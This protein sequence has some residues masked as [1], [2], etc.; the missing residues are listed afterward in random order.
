[1]RIKLEHDGQFLPPK[2]RDKAI[3]IVS[4]CLKAITTS[5]NDFVINDSLYYRKQ[6]TGKVTTC[7]MNS[8]TYISKN[9][10]DNLGSIDG[11]FG[12]TPL[13]GQN[14]DG[15]IAIDFTSDGYRIR[16]RDKLLEVLH[17]YIEEQGLP[18]NSIYTLFPMFYGMYVDKG[19]YDISCLPESTK[20]L[21]TPSSNTTKFRLGV[22]F[23]TG[24][25]ASSFRALNKLFVL[26]QQRYI[27]AGVFVTSTDK[28]NS[29]T[30]IWP[31]SN[32]NGSFQE[33]RQRR[34]M[35]QISLPVIC[36]GF[37]PDRFDSNA[38]FL[39]K[40]LNLYS[41]TATGRMDDSRTR[42]VFL[43]EDGEEILRPI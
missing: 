19:L 8:A 3:D 1:M 38:Q 26:F 4:N 29:S 40:R 39:G 17:L 36:I 22:E 25:V 34:Y 12:E 7:V 33:L 31:V 37:A 14:I 35:E 42:N 18:S 10:Q 30:R 9:F 16:D 21:F 2:I 23:E 6:R 13:N 32:R 5:G 28:P 41:P 27:D 11:C 43:G 24:N 15:L 20:G